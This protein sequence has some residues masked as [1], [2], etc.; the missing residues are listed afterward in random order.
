MESMQ[1][2]IQSTAS[3]VTERVAGRPITAASSG[4]GSDSSGEVV[5]PKVSTSLSRWRFTFTNP[6]VVL[7]RHLQDTTHILVDLGRICVSN[8]YSKMEKISDLVEK[9]RISILEMNIKSAAHSAGRDL[10]LFMLKK[11]DMSITHFSPRTVTNSPAFPNQKVLG[12]I[13]EIA[14][15]L[16]EAQS[17]LFFDI[18]EL[19]LCALPPRYATHP[20]SPPPAPPV[21]IELSEPPL[22][23]QFDAR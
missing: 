23:P 21:S 19:N 12:K 5:V 2:L 15:V 9:I 3:R 8:S 7:P 17:Q 11:T 4:T 22:R 6:V 16:T 10:P 1:S 13:P 20:S 18:V 14:L